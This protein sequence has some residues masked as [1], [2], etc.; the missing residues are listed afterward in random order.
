MF[1]FAKEYVKNESVSLSLK[2]GGYDA[3]LVS[4]QKQILWK[5]RNDMDYKTF[6]EEFA[7]DLQQKLHENGIED[8]KMEFHKIEKAN[9]NYEAL[10]V[11]QEGSNVGINFNIGKAFAEYEKTGD[12]AAV[13]SEATDALKT[14][15]EN[16]P[17]ISVEQLIDYESMR[18]KLTI[19]VISAEKNADL[20]EKIPHERIEDLAVVYRFILDSNEEG[21]TSILATNDIIDRMGI[22][23]EQLKADALENAP[24]IRP[25][26]I[27]GMGEVMREMMEP[28]LLEM[29][30]IPAE[31][32]ELM[33]VATVPDR[34][35]GAGVLA[36]QDFMDQAAEKLGGDFFILPSSIHEILLLPDD[37]NMA[38][39]DL[40]NMV[41]EV[42]ATQVSP[43]ERLTDNVYHYDAKDH[44]FELAEK[45]EARQQEKA[46]QMEEQ[47]EE[48]GS[49]LKELKNKQKETAAKQPGKDTVDKGAKAKGG[50]AL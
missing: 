15:F 40:R 44:I 38:V 12:Y 46:A 8:V 20:L 36:Y 19:E 5:E 43:E 2:S 13:L 16:T 31:E 42:N 10:T 27:K 30:G 11:V 28:E 24:E 48:H 14:G 34:N 35:S 17:A 39:D 45:F 21:R 37:G 25:A 18:E 1:S 7:E 47:S 4:G 23:Q 33:Y 9:E 32:D 26:V 29:L 41:I 49:V 22:S 3:F 50:E 6:K